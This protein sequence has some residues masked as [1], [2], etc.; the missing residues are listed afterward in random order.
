MRFKFCICTAAVFPGDHK[1][2]HEVICSSSVLHL[3]GSGTL[4]AGHLSC[5]C[6][7]HHGKAYPC[8]FSL[9]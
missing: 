9:A 8:A 4:M 5:A 1:R 2:P 3:L 7:E 6:T